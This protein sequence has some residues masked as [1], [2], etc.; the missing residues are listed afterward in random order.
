MVIPFFGGFASPL[1]SANRGLWCSTHRAFVLLG[2]PRVAL[3]CSSTERRAIRL[4]LS[5]VLTQLNCGDNPQPAISPESRR[6]QKTRRNRRVSWIVG[7][8]GGARP[9][10][11]AALAARGV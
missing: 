6:T 3:G 9:T 7:L 8:C 2:A 4:A 1:A 11:S 5:V 10:L